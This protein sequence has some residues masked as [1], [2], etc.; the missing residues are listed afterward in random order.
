MSC[1]NSLNRDYPDY[2]EYSTRRL[3]TE[4]VQL[5][6]DTDFLTCCDCTDDCQVGGAAGRGRTQQCAG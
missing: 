4:G 6:L 3:P 5:N 2:V 1:V